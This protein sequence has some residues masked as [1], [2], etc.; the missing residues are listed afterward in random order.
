MY[1]IKDRSEEDLT[2]PAKCRHLDC[3]VP[4]WMIAGVWSFM[5][6]KWSLGLVIYGHKY[7][8]LLTREYI[9]L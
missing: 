5:A 6:A 2:K 7:M 3:H 9:L 8:K 4:S 1:P